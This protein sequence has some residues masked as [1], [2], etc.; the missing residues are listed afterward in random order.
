ML[1]QN[2]FDSVQKG[3]KERK[4]L[5]PSVTPK[6]LW[7]TTDFNEGWGPQARDYIRNE[8]SL[9]CKQYILSQKD[10]SE[11]DIMRFIVVTTAK[12]YLGMPYQHHHITEWDP[13]KLKNYKEIIQ[14]KPPN[15][16]QYN[17]V[18]LDCSNFTSWVYNFGLGI[19]FTQDITTQANG[20]AAPGRVLNP[21]E[22]LLPGDLLY[23][24]GNPPVMDVYQTNSSLLDMSYIYHT[25]LYIGDSKLI[26]TLDVNGGVSQKKLTDA[27]Y[28]SHYSHARRVI[29]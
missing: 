18:G 3:L 22:P 25:A 13:K 26:D 7:Y 29:E 19:Q 24:Y 23:F 2:C 12:S 16:L 14:T 11:K 1:K 27:W 5:N 10:L 15:L 4:K 17:S 20:P 9:E 8:I 28:K 21:S 6:Q